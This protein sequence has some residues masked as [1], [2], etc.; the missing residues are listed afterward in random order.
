MSSEPPRRARPLT[1]RTLMRPFGIELQIHPSWIISLIVL[2]VAAYNGFPVDPAVTGARKIL[3]AVAFGVAIAACIV[4]HE[5]SHSLTARVYRLPVRKITLFA[6][7]GVSQIEK[8]APTPSAEFAIALAGPLASV[9]I[10]TVFG[11][12][13]RLLHPTAHHGIGVWGELGY[14]NVLLALFNLVP[15]FP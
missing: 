13:A 3:L 9:V 15:A 12:V 7:G 4:I 8:E 2:S 14:V 5:L 10:A 1:G 6:F 11:G